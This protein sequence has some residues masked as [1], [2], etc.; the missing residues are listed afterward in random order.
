MEHGH[1]PGPRREILVGTPKGITHGELNAWSTHEFSWRWSPEDS[2]K[3][4][5]VTP[6]HRSTGEAPSDPGEVP[7]MVACELVGNDNELPPGRQKA[8]P[9]VCTS[10]ETSSFG[11][12]DSRRGCMAADAWVE[13]SRQPREEAGDVRQPRAGG[14]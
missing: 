10:G 7:T 11:S 14:F 12:T 8:C 5:Q 13:S 3:T 2:R 1:L 9:D 4:Y 6:W